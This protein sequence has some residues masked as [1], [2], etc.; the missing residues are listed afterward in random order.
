MGL[1]AC[2]QVS[3]LFA[4]LTW[5]IGGGGQW[6]CS[7]FSAVALSVDGWLNHWDLYSR[8]FPRLPSQ[9]A[10]IKTS[11]IENGASSEISEC[12]RAEGH[13]CTAIAVVPCIL[14]N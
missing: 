14:L 9:K 2:A 5:K 3:V 12:G 13:S 7:F 4:A 6:C 10:D 8:A 1:V 11:F